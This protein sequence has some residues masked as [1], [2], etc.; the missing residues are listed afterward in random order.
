MCP[1]SQ[2]TY[3]NPIAIPN[4]PKG[5]NQGRYGSDFRELADPTV[6]FHDNQWYLYP[7]CGMAY[8]SKDF[9]TWEH[10]RLSPEDIG[11]APTVVKHKDKFL[12]TAM[13]RPL[14]MA[15]HPLGP[16]HEV[17]TFI[18]PD[19]TQVKMKDPMLFSDDDGKLYAYWGII[20]YFDP[21]FWGAELDQQEPWKL[22]SEPVLLGGFDP[23]QEWQRFGEWN[24]DRNKRWLEGVFM[25]KKQ[26]TYY[27]TYAAPGTQFGT[28]A[29]GAFRSQSPLEGFVAQENNPFLMKRYGL[30]RGTG[31]GCVVEGPNDTIWAFYTCCTG[32]EHGFE[33]RIGFDA[34]GIDENGN[35]FVKE[36]TEIPQWAPGYLQKPELGNG[37]GLL[38]LTFTRNHTGSSYREGRNPIYALD[39]SMLSWWQ[40]LENDPDKFLEVNLESDFHIHASRI[41]WRDVGLHYESGRCPGPFGYRIEAWNTANEAWTLVLDCSNN[42]IDYLID[43]RMFEPFVTKKVRL[44]IVS[45]PIGIEP[46]VISFTVFGRSE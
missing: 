19:G 5:Y 3:C 16:F 39:D 40:P 21:G 36:A 14:W 38:P 25:F 31:H 2:T 18:K 9:V 35:L 7:S 20:D 33:R 12:L 10:H 4:Y 13:D 42:A 44:K 11:Y 41:I 15:D 8:V 6:I 24:E 17:G 37:A 45:S 32:Y 29:M 34:V 26:G 30:V 27:L 46:G 1:R 23:D 28:Y 43:Y 22:I